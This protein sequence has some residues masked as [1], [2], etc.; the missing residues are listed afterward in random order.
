MA[1]M[2]YLGIAS[3]DAPNSSLVPQNR[4]W[5]GYREASFPVQRRIF[6][7]RCR[8]LPL[9]LQVPSQVR[10]DW[11]L[12][13]PILNTFSEGPTGAHPGSTLKH[14]ACRCEA[15]PGARLRWTESSGATGVCGTGRASGL[16]LSGRGLPLEN[17]RIWEPC[18]VTGLDPTGPIRNRGDL[19][20]GCSLKLF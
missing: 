1:Y 20:S 8:S 2:E 13:A 10:Y 17:G 6:F 11:T 15:P 9:H 7:E 3:P 19:F 4:D 5:F 18:D 14:R 16:G 12:L